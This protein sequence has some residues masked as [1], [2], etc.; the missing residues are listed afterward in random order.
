MRGIVEVDLRRYVDN[1]GKIRKILCWNEKD[2]N[3]IGMT[4]SIQRKFLWKVGHIFASK[5]ARVT[6]RNEISGLSRCNDQQKLGRACM[7]HE[8]IYCVLR[9]TLEKEKIAASKSRNAT[10]YF[11]PEQSGTR[12]HDTQ[13]K[14]KLK[15]QLK[16]K[17]SQKHWRGAICFLND[18]VEIALQ[19]QIARHKMKA[20]MQ[21][22][23]PFPCCISLFL[24]SDVE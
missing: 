14:L 1:K 12:L 23:T 22:L 7:S 21:D 9:V 17:A 24:L 15:K 6:K 11:S 20:K 16:E 2:E 18:F 10:K 19:S 3:Y 5:R 4:T 8:R 13:A